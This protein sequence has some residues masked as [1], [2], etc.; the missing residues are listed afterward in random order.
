MPLPKDGMVCIPDG[1]GLGM[2]P[3]P[4]VLERYFV[5]G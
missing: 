1:E 4:R 5:H 2:D 3:D